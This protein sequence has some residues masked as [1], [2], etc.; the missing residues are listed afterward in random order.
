MTIFAT[1]AT[2]PSFASALLDVVGR[3]H[4]I[5]VHFPI[6]LVI[7]A[8]AFEMTRTVIERLRRNDE[9]V[10]S[11]ATVTLWCVVLGAIAAG[12]SAWTGW[13]YADDLHGE[14]GSPAAVNLHRWFGVAALG[15]TVC[16][17]VVLLA[18]GRLLP[19]RTLGA[20]RALLL[21]AAVLV[22]ISGHFGGT[23]VHGKNHL[24]GPLLARWRAPATPPPAETDDA[25]S[26]G[27]PVD[28]PVL[29]GID[30]TTMVR[31]ILED[32]CYGCHA[33]ERPKAGLRLDR[34]AGIRH[35]VA[36]GDVAGSELVERINLP[37]EVRGHMPPFG[38]PVAPDER[39]V[40]AAWI[41]QGAELPAD[42]GTDTDTDADA[43]TD[44]DTA[45]GA[46]AQ[47]DTD[48]DTGADAETDDR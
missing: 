6:A 4:V 23:L 38:D 47:M 34:E 29:P 40:I 7:T 11:V 37:P 31:P 48:T 10:S 45:T 19:R 25:D 2:D 35:V 1:A 42:F 3:S 36:A 33:S 24:L 46:D 43:Q 32:R 18:A 30:F 41:A 28:A 22:A 5:L 21:I 9:R 12:A 8:A 27:A 39:A 26:T 17:A 20:G 16:A 14:D 13:A 44:A 15:A